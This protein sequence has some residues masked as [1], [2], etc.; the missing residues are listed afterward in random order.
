VG[1]GVHRTFLG[2]GVRDQ[3]G[4]A[5]LDQ[6]FGCGGCS[7]LIAS[8]S[9]GNERFHLDGKGTRQLRVMVLDGLDRLGVCGAGCD[10]ERAHENS[11]GS[12]R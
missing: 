11:F 5:P 1:L 10:N 3:L 7:G 9:S 6:G 12:T 4:L 2:E 8:G